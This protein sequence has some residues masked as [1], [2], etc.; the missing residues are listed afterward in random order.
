MPASEQTGCQTG[1]SWT[2]LGGLTSLNHCLPTLAGH[3]NQDKIKKMF[4]ERSV[5]LTPE[6]QFFQTQNFE[7]E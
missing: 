4:A 2:L 1:F 3:R 6:R 5:D 7:S